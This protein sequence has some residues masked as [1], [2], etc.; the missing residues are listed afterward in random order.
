MRLITFNPWVNFGSNK[1]ILNLTNWKPL[2]QGIN[3][4]KK[5]LEVSVDWFTD[6]KNLSLYDAKYI[7]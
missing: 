3:G 5:G 6:P 4:F 2:Y 7:I 1:K